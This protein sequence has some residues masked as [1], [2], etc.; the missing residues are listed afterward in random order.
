[1]GNLVYNYVLRN[2]ECIMF[3]STREVKLLNS[4]MVSLEKNYGF[5]IYNKTY[6]NGEIK[7]ILNGEG[8]ETSL[9]KLIMDICRR[10]RGVYCFKLLL[11]K[12]TNLNNGVSDEISKLEQNKDVP[13]KTKVS[14]PT[15][16]ISEP[17]V[18]NY[19]TL[20]PVKETQNF[21]FKRQTEFKPENYIPQKDVD[22]VPFGFYS[23]LKTI[24]ETKR[25][26]PC[27][28]TGPSGLGKNL[29]VSQICHNINQPMI[30]VSITEE[31]S[32]DDLIGCWTLQ[33]GETIWKEGPIVFAA[34]HGML[35]VLD[36]ID[37]A[38]PKIM[39]L[40]SILNGDPIYIE[41]L[42]EVVIPKTGFN[43][44][45]T[46]N[47][48]GFGESSVYIGTQ[49]LNEAFLERFKIMF[50][51]GFPSATILKKIVTKKLTH[52]GLT[53]EQDETFGKNLTQ[54]VDYV[55]SAFKSESIDYFISNRRLSA[56][57]E[58]YSIFKD[59]VQSLTLGLTRFPK[60]I[61]QTFLSLYSK[62]DSS[63]NLTPEEIFEQ[64]KKELDTFQ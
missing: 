41:A 39:C 36:E 46:G 7:D 13:V 29:T 47:T 14:E 23:T 64:M 37:L 18:I 22:F 1:M 62:I 44:I 5:E 42:G 45:A 16:D 40:Q 50:D 35:V 15:V 60:P 26:F 59:V 24:L 17:T 54:F 31:T 19:T 21:V 10:E 49:A 30:L 9:R 56:I 20:K 51:H 53:T 4:V 3:T 27:Y 8:L 55:S 6:S 12:L 48:K 32:D 43:I 61:I 34:K 33:N 28:I 38:T 52:L 11:Q 58:T 2:Q 25:F 63:L 57:I